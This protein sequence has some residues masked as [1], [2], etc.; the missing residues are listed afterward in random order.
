MK[1][2]FING[3]FFIGAKN[4]TWF[5]LNRCF[6]H[7]INRVGRPPAFSGLMDFLPTPVEPARFL[8]TFWRDSLSLKVGGNQWTGGENQVS[9]KNSERESLQTPVSYSV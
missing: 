3:G 2:D 5:Y 8:P 7:G 4:E 9:V 1:I 6:T